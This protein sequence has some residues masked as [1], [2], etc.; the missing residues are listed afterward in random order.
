MLWASALHRSSLV[1]V[2][3]ALAISA[4]E[5]AIDPL[6]SVSDT[7]MVSSADTNVS[8]REKVIMHFGFFDSRSGGSIGKRGRLALKFSTLF[9]LEA[10][11]RV[12]A[13]HRDI[14]PALMPLQQGRRVGVACCGGIISGASG[15]SRRDGAVN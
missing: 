4:R 12:T 3:R 14:C 5:T 13:C 6:L 9:A 11:A 2:A 7:S 15:S 8:S 10:E 1:R